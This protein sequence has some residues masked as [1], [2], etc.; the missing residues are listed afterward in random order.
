MGRAE[1]LDAQEVVRRAA[2]T[3]GAVP[4]RW[5]EVDR[6][7]HIA[8]IEV[9]LRATATPLIAFLDDDTEPEPGWLGVLVNA[10]NDSTV[11]CVG[12]RV[13]VHGFRGK[14]H[15]DA[16]RV[17]WYGQHIGNIG[18]LE[19]RGPL[20]VDGVMEGNWAWRIDVLRNLRLDLI[21]EDGDASMYGLDLCLQA[22][23]RGW[24]LIY[25]PRARVVHHIAPRDPTLDRADLTTRTFVYS[26]NMTYIGLKHFRGFRRAIWLGWWWLVGDS[27]SRG[28]VRA[29]GD[30]LRRNGRPIGLLLTELSGK[31]EG[32]RWWKKAGP[33]RSF[34]SPRI[35]S[36]MR[37]PS[38]GST[39]ATR[40]WT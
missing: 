23:A 30:A 17:R 13:I 26:R 1:D 31:V 5:L 33:Y 32:V 39:H 19:A 38:T 16:G 21:F 10:F 25:Q 12:G 34:W 24:R 9:G 7:G 27:G 14:V 40:A 20:E 37:S 3:P 4:V 15:P 8:P 36:S 35:R 6:P 22:K 11:G 18:A 29:I 28:P 2:R